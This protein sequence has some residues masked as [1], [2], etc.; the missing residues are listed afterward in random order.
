MLATVTATAAAKATRQR[1]ARLIIN[2]GEIAVTLAAVVDRRKVRVKIYVG[3][4][5]RTHYSEKDPIRSYKAAILSIAKM[6]PHIIKMTNVN[7]TI[8]IVK[9]LFL[10][11]H[12]FFAIFYLN[13]LLVLATNYVQ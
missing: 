9:F 13:P 4:V 6:Y 12:S 8:I 1:R 7:N 10:S 5:Y 2:T 3:N 11:F